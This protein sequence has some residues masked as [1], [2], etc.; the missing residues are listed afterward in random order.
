MVT[1]RVLADLIGCHDENLV[2]DRP[3]PYQRL[4]VIARGRLRECCRQHDDS[5]TTQRQHSEQLG[6]AQ[7]VAD[8]HAELCAVLQ[9]T[10]DDLLTRLVRVGLAVTLALDLHVEHMQLAINRLNLTVRA[11]VHGGVGELLAP[12]DA[13]GDRAGDKIELQLCCRRTRPSDRASVE[14][15]CACTQVLWGAHD[16]P[17]LGQH[18]QRRAS[19]RRGA[20]LL[21]RGRDVRLDIR[22]GIQL[23][24]G[25]LHMPS[26]LPGV[27]VRG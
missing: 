20:H 15:L 17:L 18:D 4:P 11:D 23:N 25:S 24:G 19:G 22:T 9:Y 12:L 10:D 27:P 13:L 5:R 2:L 8:R 26:E 14:R 21:V 3:G 7:V 16:R 6:E 1:P